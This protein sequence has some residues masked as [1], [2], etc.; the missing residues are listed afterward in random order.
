MWQH[1]LNPA[2]ASEWTRDCAVIN[3][4]CERA[5]QE[6]LQVRSVRAI[7]EEG[8]PIFEASAIRTLSHVQIAVREPSVI[9]E[10]EEL[11]W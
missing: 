3:W 1:A 11:R 4:Y 7:F 8:D 10:M 6:G 9:L 5:A 2:P